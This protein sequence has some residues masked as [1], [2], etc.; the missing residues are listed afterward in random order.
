MFITVY[1][2][3]VVTFQ[4]LK[5]S[6]GRREAAALATFLQLI[7]K[8]SPMGESILRFLVP[9]DSNTQAVRQKGELMMLNQIIGAWSSDELSLLT[10]LRGLFHETFHRSEIDELG[11]EPVKQLLSALGEVT[12]YPIA[13]A[14]ILHINGRWYSRTIGKQLPNLPEWG[15]PFQAPVDAGL[16]DCQPWGWV[17]LPAAIIR[18][19]G[20][21]TI[22][23]QRD[24]SPA[25]LF[26]GWL[27][28]LL[29]VVFDS[30]E[31]SEAEAEYQVRKLEFKLLSWADANLDLPFSLAEEIQDTESS[32]NGWA[33]EIGISLF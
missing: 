16:Y 17:T 26:A 33:R 20:I 2:G 11:G 10:M 1:Y 15:T 5:V 3:T 19:G 22:L 8:V 30:S 23:L 31:L 29:H 28:E 25:G 4:A 14:V 32:Q 24:L 21:C 9:V 18:Q 27:H 12:C 13:D 6:F 7:Y